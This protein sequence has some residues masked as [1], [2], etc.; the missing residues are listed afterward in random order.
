MFCFV[1]SL[2][3]FPVL[4]ELKIKPRWQQR[5]ILTWFTQ[6]QYVHFCINHSRNH[7]ADSMKAIR[8]KQSILTLPISLTSA[9]NFTSAA[10]SLLFLLESHVFITIFL[11][12]WEL[13]GGSPKAAV[14]ET[15]TRTPEWESS[16]LF[17]QHVSREREQQDETRY[18]AG[19]QETQRYSSSASTL[20]SVL[21]WSEDLWSAV[22]FSLF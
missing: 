7:S 11:V 16:F 10:A 18:R 14:P 1:L 5:K 6:L 21:V 8:K 3:T 2:P 13:R 22:W 12:S 4:S 20:H 19:A 15:H 9:F 17:W